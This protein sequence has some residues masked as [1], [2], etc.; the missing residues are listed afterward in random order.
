MAPKTIAAVVK[1]FRLNLA[2]SGPT[3]G[4]FCHERCGEV[5]HQL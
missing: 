3:S 1:Y 5:E 4:A 2:D